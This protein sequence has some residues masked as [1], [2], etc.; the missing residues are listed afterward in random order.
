MIPP[1]SLTESNYFLLEFLKRGRKK[2]N[3]PQPRLRVESYWGKGHLSHIL[4][5]AGN[6]V[7]GVVGGWDNGD[8]INTQLVNI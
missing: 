5:G 1:I 2:E 4:H 3:V 6:D 7:H 8:V